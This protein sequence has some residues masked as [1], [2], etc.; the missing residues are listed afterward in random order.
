[1]N[2]CER[3]GKE[4]SYTT[5]SYFN[6]QM[7]GKECDERERAH[8]DFEKARRIERDAVMSGNLNYVGI[9]LPDDLK[10]KCI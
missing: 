4:S 2:R 7:I 6:T 3:C 1:M 10:Y 9:G 8:P 5:G